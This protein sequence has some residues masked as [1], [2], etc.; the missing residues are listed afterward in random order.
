MELSYSRSRKSDNDRVSGRLPDGRA[1]SVHA[2]NSALTASLHADTPSDPGLGRSMAARMAAA[3][4]PGF[5][6]SGGEAAVAGGAGVIQMKPMGEAGHAPP[7]SGSPEAIRTALERASSVSLADVRVHYDSPKP[8]EIGA[9]AY[10]RGSD[11]FMGPGQEKYLGHELTHVVQQKQGLVRSTGSVDGMPVNT[12]P[13]LESEA[14]HMQV[15]ASPEAASAPASGVVQG[16]FVDSSGKQLSDR[17][18]EV[19]ISM[20]VDSL[21]S[22]E[23]YVA[24]RKGPDGTERNQAKLSSAYRRQKEGLRKRYMKMAQDK[25]PHVAEDEMSKELNAAQKSA[26]RRGFKLDMSSL[27][28]KVHDHT[29][30]NSGTQYSLEQQRKKKHNPTLQLDAQHTREGYLATAGEFQ[31]DPTEIFDDVRSIPE[32]D[33][34]TTDFSFDELREARMECSTTFK[35]AKENA[36]REGATQEDLARQADREKQFDDA[37]EA[38]RQGAVDLRKTDTI[39]FG[40]LYPILCRINQAARSGD[41][42]W[43]DTAGGGHIRGRGTGTANIKAVG[44]GQLPEDVFRTF[45]TIA[46]KMNEIKSITDPDLQKTQ[47]IKLAAFAYQITI[48]EHIFEDGNGRSCRLLADTI[49]QTFGLPPHAPMQAE[50]KLSGTIGKK[51]DFD[52]GAQ[53][54]LAG[55]KQGDQIMRDHAAAQAQPPVSSGPPASPPTQLPA[56]GPAEHPPAVTSAAPPPAAPTAVQRP[57]GLPP[58]PNKP[59]PPT[60]VRQPPA[61]PT[62]VQRPAGLPPVPNKPLPPTPVRQPPAAAAAQPAAAASKSKK[63]WWEFWK[64]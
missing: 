27:D 42:V 38:S 54:L 18:V 53:T 23:K 4:G 21:G 8:A 51:I 1:G 28:Y 25:K 10:A 17:D 40:D 43:A 37:A 26:G 56:T 45:S 7:V 61:A 48:S 63:H 44:S 19:M 14:D 5:G 49:L 12:S 16:V 50:A 29:L 41:A 55:V 46:A 22:H 33:P 34:E 20:M 35:G 32:Y 30:D 58:V 11:V 31:L 36:A 57:A 24:G 2:S 39:G 13:A 6:A 60:P 9:L 15:S 47:A 62:A 59:L 64:R 3:F 52:H